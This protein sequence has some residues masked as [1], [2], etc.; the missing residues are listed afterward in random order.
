LNFNNIFFIGILEA[1]SI[2]IPGVSGTALFMSL[3][4]Y[5]ELLLII[6]S[7]NNIPLLLLFYFGTGVG[8]ILL[9]NILNYL[10]QTKEYEFCYLVFSMTL[11]SIL[12]MI[13]K[14]LYFTYTFKMLL[15]G[16]VLFLL[17]YY[18]SRKL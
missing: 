3:G 17:G 15:I 8:I 5:E 14:T 9:S 13:K 18:I 6:S 7:L 4:I 2:I 12:I 16:I 10:I 11:I 1:I